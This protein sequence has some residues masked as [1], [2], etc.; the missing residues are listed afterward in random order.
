[1]NRHGTQ[2]PAPPSKPADL[3]TDLAENY[4]FWHEPENK[5]MTNLPALTSLRTPD[6]SWDLLQRQGSVISNDSK[7]IK[8]RAPLPPTMP[9]N[10]S[11]GR[12][13][14][15]DML[16]WVE[17]RDLSHSDGSRTTN[18]RTD[19]SPGQRPMTTITIRQFKQSYWCLSD[20][21]WPEWVGKGCINHP[22]TTI[23]HRLIPTKSQF[24]YL[25][26][27]HQKE[28]LKCPWFPVKTAGSKKTMYNWVINH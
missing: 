19:Y 28:G 22:N 23:P 10:Q 21:K 17:G 9:D 4:S 20:Y 16:L 11:L 14:W 3:Y 26:E 15:T 25:W 13:P 18:G 8:Q 12:I 1:M 5:K 27:F 6:G 24:Q 7:N 2:P